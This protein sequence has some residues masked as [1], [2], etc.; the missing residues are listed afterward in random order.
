MHSGKDDGTA[1]GYLRAADASRPVA[2]RRSN[3]I[4]VVPWYSRVKDKLEH[5]DQRPFPGQVLFT[6]EQIVSEAHIA[7]FGDRAH[8]FHCRERAIDVVS[9]WLH[10]TFNPA[11][12]SSRAIYNLVL[13]LFMSKMMLVVEIE[14]PLLMGSQQVFPGCACDKNASRRAFFAR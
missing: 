14:E 7:G 3:A 4:A 9:S 13:A 10:K 6:V 8:L 5:S 12:N 2:T 11:Q 1:V